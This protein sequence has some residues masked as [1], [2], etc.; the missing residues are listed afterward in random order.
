ML[1][2]IFLAQVSLAAGFAGL[3]VS[4]VLDS[5]RAQG[6]TFIYNTEIVSDNLVVVAEP[7]AASGIALAKEILEPHGLALTEV[8]PRTFAVVR[9]APVRPPV[10]NATHRAASTASSANV[11]EV[12]VQTSRYALAS[13]IEGLHAFLDQAQVAN[14]P[15]LGDETLQAVQ[16]LPGAAVNGLSSLG[17][18]RGGVPNETAILLDGLRLYEPFHL[19]NYLSPISLLDSRVIGGLDIYFG[20]FPVNY[21]DRMSAI[22]DAHSVRP[23]TSRYYEL[24]LTLFHASALG[25]GTFDEG[26]GDVLLSARRSNLGELSQLAENDFGRPEYS[27]GFARLDYTF[28]DA[29]RGSFS[30]LL[31]H[32]RITAIRSSGTEQAQDE[33]SNSYLWGTLTHQWSEAFSSQLIASYTEVSGDRHGEVDDPGRR[34]GD[35]R[36]DRNFDVIGLRLDNELHNGRLTQRFG[37]EVRRLRADYDYAAEVNFAADFPFPGSPPRTESRSVVLHPDG[38]EVS[39]YW[40]ARFVMSSRW[41]LEGG[42]RID[43]Q[44]YDG[45]GDSAQRSPRLSLLYDAGHNTRLRASWGR[46]YQSQ[47]INEL[48]VEDGVDHF[49]PAQHANHSIF[50][51]EHDFPMHLDARLELYRKDYRRVNPRFENLFDPLVL[52]PELQFDRVRIAADTARADGIELWLNWHPGGQWS[53]WLSYTWSKVQERIDGEDFYRSWDQ[54]HAA[55]LGLAWVSGPWAVTLAD[56]FHSGWP[57]TQLSLATAPTADDSPVIIGPRNA[58]RFDDFNSLDLRVTRTFTLAHGTLD[59]FFEVTNLT[60][61]QNPCCSDYQV[62][63]DGAGNPV[64]QTDTT[65]WLPLVPSLGVL[66]K[67]GKQ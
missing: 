16:R 3:R 2:L 10:D 17:P 19:K 4:D 62:V 12:V 38:Y 5:L 11:E 48:Q 18:I 31:S 34:N 27:D 54:R 50:S 64:L 36:D 41:T 6:L 9:S 23:P 59:A 20:G 67:Y 13:D 15:R 1:L 55:S 33:S 14:L 22:I 52:L 46:F 7:R 29:T 26:R 47:G 51:V 40:D 28:N 45:S 32:D 66:W 30:A 58:V 57:T 8:G 43:A 65:N 63:R 21:G 56:T 39:G 42:L 37:A 24:G 25:Y 35:V 61:R 49:Y 53:G 60:S 44:T